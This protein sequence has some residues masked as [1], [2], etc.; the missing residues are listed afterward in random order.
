MNEI[1][2]IIDKKED[3]FEEY[4]L[5]LSQRNKTGKKNSIF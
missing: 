1:E 5:W 3:L 4:K 2:K